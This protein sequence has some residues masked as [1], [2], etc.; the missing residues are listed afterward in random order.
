VTLLISRKTAIPTG[1]RHDP[2]FCSSL[3]KKKTVRRTRSGRG[4]LAAGGK[5][6]F[7]KIVGNFLEAR[8]FIDGGEKLKFLGSRVERKTRLPGQRGQAIQWRKGRASYSSKPEKRRI[9][10]QGHLKPLF[11][12]GLT[13]GNKKP[14][15]L[16]GRKDQPL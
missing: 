7:S 10:P 8:R 6:S 5:Q 3:Q 15:L 12:K 13:R 14:S 4:R 1:R 9:Q 16:R 2:T 11:G